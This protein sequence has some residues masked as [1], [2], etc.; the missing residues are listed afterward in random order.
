MA[1]LKRGPLR[2][3]G[4]PLSLELS[5]GSHQA[6]PL[7]LVLLDPAFEALDCPPQTGLLAFEISERCSERAILAL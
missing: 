1:G 6:R 5:H 2:L 3:E 7:G 4:G